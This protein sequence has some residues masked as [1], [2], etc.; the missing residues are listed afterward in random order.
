MLTAPIEKPYKS[1]KKGAA[2]RPPYVGRKAKVTVRQV[3]QFFGVLKRQLGEGCTGTLFNSP[4]VMTG[5]ACGV[6]RKTVTRSLSGLAR[7]DDCKLKEP[8][9]KNTLRVT[10]LKKYGQEWGEAVHHFV[11][12]ALE[13]EGNVTVA[14][15]H[16]RLSSVYASFPMCATTLYGFLRALGFSHRKEENKIF[17]LPESSSETESESESEHEDEDM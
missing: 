8:D 15:L 4:T 13:E 17:I 10:T 1:I 5:L 7:S 6:S 11:S 9:G 16:R 2:G 14:D 3:R 12:T